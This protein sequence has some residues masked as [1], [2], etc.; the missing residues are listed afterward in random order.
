MHSKVPDPEV[1]LLV[2]DHLHQRVLPKGQR[3][4]RSLLHPVATREHLLGRLDHVLLLMHASQSVD[5]E[6]R[7]DARPLANVGT[8]DYVAAARSAAAWSVLHSA[9]GPMR[10]HRHRRP[11]RRR[12]LFAAEADVQYRRVH[13]KLHRRALALQLHKLMRA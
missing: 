8:Y 4:L 9:A 7:N 2:A 13:M 1:D 11:S 12:R 3:L 10:I 5:L 6:T